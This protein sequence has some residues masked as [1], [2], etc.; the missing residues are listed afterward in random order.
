MIDNHV[1]EAVE[2]AGPYVNSQGQAVLM[3][4]DHYSAVQTVDDGFD[5]PRLSPPLRLQK[6]S[7]KLGGW[8]GILYRVR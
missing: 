1:L 5:V 2:R 4:V 3:N 8:S 6:Q 7:V